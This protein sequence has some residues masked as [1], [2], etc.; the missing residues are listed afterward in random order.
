MKSRKYLYGLMGLLSLL[1]FVGI[2][3]EERGFLAFFAFLV[4]FE[5]FF[6]K[7]DEMLEEYMNKSASRAFYAGMLTTAFVSLIAV[8]I[9]SETAN[10]ALAMGFGYGWS[11]SIITYAL[12]TAYYGFRERW[13]ILNDKKQD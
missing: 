7:S 1:G 8:F 2:F 13:G 11:L 4:D 10:K 12:S 6:M 3:T 9:G 5:Y